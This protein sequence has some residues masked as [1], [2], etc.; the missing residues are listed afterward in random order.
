M[1][2]LKHI[3]D[4]PRSPAEFPLGIMT[5]ENRDT[6]SQMREKMVSAGQNLL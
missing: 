1:S 6:W 3:L 4:D 2:H 5:S